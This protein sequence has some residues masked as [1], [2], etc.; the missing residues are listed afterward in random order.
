VGQ[1]PIPPKQSVSNVPK[2]NVSVK[3]NN[4]ATP[5]VVNTTNTTSSNSVVVFRQLRGDGRLEI[6]PKFLKDLSLNNGDFVK[7]ARTA[8]GLK[9]SPYFTTLDEKCLKINSQGRLFI[10]S[11]ILS[12]YTFVNNSVKIELCYGEILLG[13]TRTTVNPTLLFTF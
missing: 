13:N 12:K 10:P 7:I 2:T 4:V 3:I 8:N 11:D 9:I 1:K 5:P 6:P